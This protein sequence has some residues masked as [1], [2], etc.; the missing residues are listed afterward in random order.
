MERA[1]K[2]YRL[3]APEIDLY[4]LYLN[5]RRQYEIPGLTPRKFSP[6]QDKATG[7]GAVEFRMHGPAQELGLV[8]DTNYQGR[9]ESEN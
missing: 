7:V 2:L 1:E 9:I 4:E 8:A 6:R 5:A 3:R